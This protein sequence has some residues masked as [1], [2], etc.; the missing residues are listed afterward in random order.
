MKERHLELSKKIFNLGVSLT[1]EARKTKD[2]NIS[3]LG[4]IMVML[5]GI[6]PEKEDLIDFDLLCSM[7]SAKKLFEEIPNEIIMDI[8]NKLKD[9]GDTNEGFNDLLDDLT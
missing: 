6:V 3:I 2:D 8:I 4:K 5:S 9:G 7:F 1:N